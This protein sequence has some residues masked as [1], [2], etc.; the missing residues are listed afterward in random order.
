VPVGAP[1]LAAPAPVATRPAVLLGS[2]AAALAHLVMTVAMAVML[3][4][5]V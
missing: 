5:M 1:A 3:L 4:G 2:R